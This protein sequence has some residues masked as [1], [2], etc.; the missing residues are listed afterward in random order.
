MMEYRLYSVEAIKSSLR[1]KNI[2]KTIFGIV[3]LIVLPMF[4]ISEVMPRIG[5]YMDIAFVL[6]WTVILTTT[7]ISGWTISGDN[8][9][10]QS[11]IASK[12]VKIASMEIAMIDSDSGWYPNW[13]TFGVGLPG[14]C[15]GYFR[16]ENKNSLL[17]FEHLSDGKLLLIIA[18]DK[19]YI[20]GHAGVEKLYVE[21][22]RMGA[23]E[24]LGISKGN[25][26]Y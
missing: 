9:Y 15:L 3:L 8:F 17:V 19:F 25:R 18:E 1:I 13:R 4:I 26:F 22:I 2:V 6:L 10:F 21:L 11:L 16:A 14:L 12:R 5:S 23:K 20:I 24:R 7:S